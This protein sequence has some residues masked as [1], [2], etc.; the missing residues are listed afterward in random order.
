MKQDEIDLL[1]RYLDGAITPEELEA[2]EDLFNELRSLNRELS[3]GN[4]I[5]P[6]QKL[7]VRDADGM[8]AGGG[9]KVIHRVARGET[10]WDIAYRYGTTVGKIRKWNG[11]GRNRSLIRPG[12]QLTVYLQ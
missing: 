7:Y 4:L 1:H 5:R 9:D 12:D 10:L 3:D 6:G 8:L 2:L 11:M